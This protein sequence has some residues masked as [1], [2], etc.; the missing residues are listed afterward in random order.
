VRTRLE[1]A[2]EEGSRSTPSDER[3]LGKKASGRFQTV[4]RLKAPTSARTMAT[5][6]RK[7]RNFETTIPPPI[8]KSKSKSTKI[9]S[10]MSFTSDRSRS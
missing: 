6:R 5:I 7:N 9:Q 3:V 4:E 8:A 1:G 2:D 10:N